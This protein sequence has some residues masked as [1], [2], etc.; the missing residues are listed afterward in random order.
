VIDPLSRRFGAP[1]IYNPHLLSRDELV[2][3]FSVRLALLD[4]LLA[5]VAEARPGQAPQHHLIVGQRGMGKT[6]LLR[7]L[8]YAVDDHSGLSHAWVPLTFP[9]EQYNVGH[10]SDFWSNCLEALGAAL[11][12]R[13]LDAEARRLDAAAADLAAASQEQRSR[14]ALRLLTGTA[15][16]LGKRLLLLVDNI[17]LIF[18]RTRR[19]AWALREVL[20]RE[21]IILLVGTST[22]LLEATYEY[23]QPFYDFFAVH[24]L[25]GLSAEETME[26][27]RR[28]ADLRGAAHV[29]RVVDEDPG[30]IRTLHT[31]TG[32]NPRTVALLFTILASGLEGDVR[33]D[34]EALLD[35]C[36]PLYKARLEALPDQAQR[37]VHGL[38]VHWHPW[39]AGE[40]AADLGLEVNVVSS[41]LAR[42]AQDG[43]IEKVAYDPESK[44]GFQVAE[45]FFNI[46]YLMRTTRRAR[47]KLLW[48]VEFL[49]MFYRQQEAIEP[50]ERVA[51]IDPKDA[52]AWSTLGF[53][54]SRLRRLEG[55]E[56]AWSRALELAPGSAKALPTIALDLLV[57]HL[58][59]QRQHWATNQPML[60]A[61][62]ALARRALVEAPD[63]VGPSI[64]AAAV[65]LVSS[66]W[67]EAAELMSRVLGRGAGDLSNGYWESILYLFR[68]LLSVGTAR[69]A[70]DL[71]DEVGASDRLRPLREALAAIAQGRRS[72]LRRLAPEVTEPAERILAQLVGENWVGEAEK[73]RR[74]RGGASHRAGRRRRLA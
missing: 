24:E 52:T 60:S 44:T 28:S 26:L 5:A 62:E 38:A 27:L 54:L 30:R 17:D 48:L 12:E 74:R 73:P 10:L 36:T 37:V 59:A 47:R 3:A 9:E 2:E 56:V 18:S 14:E 32:G 49:R 63:D 34:L 13:G 71:L 29:R 1:A 16:G 50:L 69:E 46:W 20:S 45:R 31:L 35:H 65:F 21:P 40:L 25:R 53:A 33:G 23:D 67:E 7:G 15:A 61:A 8:G 4:R 42:L 70:A 64:A 51:E 19:Q 58:E 6:M 41:Q 43:V 22:H 72:Y 39:S 11:E 55:S 57:A 66:E 68:G